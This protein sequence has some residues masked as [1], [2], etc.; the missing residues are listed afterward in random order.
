MDAKKILFT[1]KE[2]AVAALRCIVALPGIVL[3]KISSA[4][5][6]NQRK[7]NEDEE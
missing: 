6:E 1:V 4:Y 2:H 7:R 3:Y 5:E